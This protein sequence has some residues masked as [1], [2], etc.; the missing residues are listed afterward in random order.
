V[1]RTA[2][3]VA[4]GRCRGEHL[5][6]GADEAPLYDYSLDRMLVDRLVPVSVQEK[7]GVSLS[8]HVQKW[9]VLRTAVIDAE[10]M[11]A[12]SSLLIRQVS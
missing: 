1:E 7:H 4:W 3:L 5:L 9:M 10:A 12:V 2:L 11:Q 8:P 6:R